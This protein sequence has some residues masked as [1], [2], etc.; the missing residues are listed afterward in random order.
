MEKGILLHGVNEPTYGNVRRQVGIIMSRENT[1]IAKTNKALVVKAAIELATAWHNNYS[2][3]YSKG[4]TP[5]LWK[6]MLANAPE[7][8]VPPSNGDVAIDLT[9][10]L[11]PKSTKEKRKH[12]VSF[13]VSYLWLIL[14]LRY[15]TLRYTH[16]LHYFTG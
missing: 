14:L 7:K 1:R 13:I 16:S 8:E 4:R 3:F 2:K 5:P 12:M 9:T 10:K 11:E 6:K 15:P